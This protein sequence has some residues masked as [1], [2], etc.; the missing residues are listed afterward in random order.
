MI[1]LISILLIYIT[2]LHYRI[3]KMSERLDGH[4]RMFGDVWEGIYKR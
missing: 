4:A 1:Y 3:T 2:W